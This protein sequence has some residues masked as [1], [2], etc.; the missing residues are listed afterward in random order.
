L[1]APS[2]G[3]G[4]AISRFLS[5]TRPSF[6]PALIC[7]ASRRNAARASTNHTPK[8]RRFGHAGEGGE[9]EAPSRGA[10]GAI[11]RFLSGTKPSFPPSLICT[12]SRRI[13]ARAS[14]YQTVFK[15]RFDRAGE[16]DELEAPSR[17]AG[18]AISRFLSGT[19]PSF[20]LA[21]I[22]TASRRITT[23]ASTNQAPKN[24]GLI[25]QGRGM[26]W[27]R[28]LAGPGRRYRAS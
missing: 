16:G 7:T 19:K 3:A 20:L 13:T 9:L 28:R 11:S 2:R 6:L 25:T 21:L 18:G 8:E 15:R 10:G 5:G 4:G 27:R 17:G 12:A 26:S 14:T 22:C 1:E 24:G 23:R